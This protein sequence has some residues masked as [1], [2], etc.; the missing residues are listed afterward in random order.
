MC[1]SLRRRGFARAQ[2]GW[3]PLMWAAEKGR[4]DCMRLLLDARADPHTKTNVRAIV[5]VGA[6]SVCACWKLV[7]CA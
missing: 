2:D 6:S 7:V 4:M 1:F 5:S 3:T